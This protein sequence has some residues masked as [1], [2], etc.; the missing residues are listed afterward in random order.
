MPRLTPSS[1]KAPSQRQL[2]VGEVIRHAIAE[3][4]T[5]GEIIDDVIT[6]HVITV[7]EVRMSPDLKIATVFVMPLGGQ[8]GPAVIKALA[9]NAKY[10]RGLISR[11]INMKFAP[12]LRFRLDDS[13]DYATKIDTLLRQDEVS[14]DLE[15]KLP[16]IEGDEE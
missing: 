8:D 7:P 3:V 5:R 4:L 2:R 15:H 1:S 6:R 11:R 13:F 10:L 9:N 16:S 14:R 12:N